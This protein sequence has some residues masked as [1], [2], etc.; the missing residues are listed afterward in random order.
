VDDLS[1]RELVDKLPNLKVM[2]EMLLRGKP[3]HQL[4][5]RASSVRRTQDGSIVVETRQSIGP[6]QVSVK[7]QF[8][9]S[10]DGKKLRYVHEVTGPRPEQRHAH[11][12]EFDV[13]TN[14]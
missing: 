4:E 5:E 6:H 9:M 1:I 10:P 13:S 2:I 3:D 14:S 7:E 11:S 8:Q 12:Y